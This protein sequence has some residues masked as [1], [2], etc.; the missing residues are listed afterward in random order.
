METVA[1]PVS[2]VVLSVPKVLTWSSA[3]THRSDQISIL[4]LLLLLL[5]ER[6][7]H[8]VHAVLHH[9]LSLLRLFEELLLLLAALLLWVKDRCGCRTQCESDDNTAT[10]G[11]APTLQPLIN[12]LY[13]KG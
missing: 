6:G 7:Q 1:E 4:L 8:L 12:A 3:L 5:L 11:G 2:V 10:Q 13:S 9:R